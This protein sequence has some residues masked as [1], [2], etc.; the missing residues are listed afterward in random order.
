MKEK[1]QICV[2]EEFHI[3]YVDPLSSKRWITTS[4]FVKCG[5]Y[6]VTSSQGA[7]CRS[8][9]AVCGEQLQNEET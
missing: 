7:Q 1:R 9:W 3:I 2:A 8:G 6:I 4:W 5:L